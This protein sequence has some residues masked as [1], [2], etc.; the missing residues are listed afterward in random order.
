MQSVFIKDNKYNFV[1]NYRHDGALRKSFNI[2]TDKTFGF[3]LELWYQNGYWKESYIPYSLSHGNKIVSNVSVY[4][5]DFLV[6]NERRRYIQLGSVMTDTAYR[7]KGLNRYL[8]EKIIDEWKNKCD[9]LFLFANDSVLNFYTRFGFSTANEYQHSV[10]L[11]K[12]TCFTAE[13]MDMTLHDNRLKLIDKI[14]HCK[15]LMQIALI[16]KQE[17]IMFYCTYI[18]K[19]CFYYLPKQDAIAVAEFKDKTVYLHDVFC[20]KDIS[21][22]EI[23]NDMTDENTKKVVFGFTP[24]NTSECTKEILKEKNSTLFIIE[25]RYKGLLNDNHLRFPVLSHT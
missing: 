10:T 13:K 22:N 4:V 14:N 25:N 16:N 20:S 7:N 9:M 15:N 17:V 8:I 6:L 24:T 21:L 2:L 5:M 1:K 3:D 11:I 12:N 18:M 23:I 19:D